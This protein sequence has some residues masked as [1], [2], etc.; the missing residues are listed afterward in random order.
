M[1]VPNSYPNGTKFRLKKDVSVLSGTFKAG[2]T[3]TVIGNSY[4]GYDFEDEDG[5]Q[6]LE[7]GLLDFDKYFQKI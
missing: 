5:H 4:R 2:S 7:T 6:L 3:M 1:F